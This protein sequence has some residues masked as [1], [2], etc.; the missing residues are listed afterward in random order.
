MAYFPFMVDIGGKTC[1]LVG[2]GAV[3]LHKA[4]I[5]SGF[6]A[7]LRVVGA[8]ILPEFAQLRPEPELLHRA[9]Q[10]HDLDGADF[11]VAATDDETMNDHISAL[12]RQRKI[13]VNVVDQKEA[14]S[15]IF[16]AMI[17]DGDLLV[18]ISTGGQSPAA[19]AC[20]KQKL[21]CHIPDY[22]PKMIDTLGE[23]RG[24]ILENVPAAKARKALFSRLLEYGDSHEGEIPLEVMKQLMAEVVE[25]E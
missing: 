10:D 7:R 9:F 19:A 3:A 24:C 20:V 6:G 2:G 1:L 12:C 25:N 11:V 5:L 21:R 13:P 16:P 8:R 18:A 22:Y 15:F 23:Y 14:C 4:K 17:H